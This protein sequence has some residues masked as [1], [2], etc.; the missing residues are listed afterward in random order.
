MYSKLQPNYN[1]ISELHTGIDVGKRSRDEILN[2]YSLEQR[3]ILV[4]DYQMEVARSSTFVGEIFT[5]K[6]HYRNLTNLFSS[7]RV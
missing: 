2:L 6:L 4:L 3:N 7:K 5:N 1:M